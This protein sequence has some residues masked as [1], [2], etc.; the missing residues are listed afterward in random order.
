MAFSL[1]LNYFIIESRSEFI[2][3]R[4]L[5]KTLN[6][7]TV[8]K[9]RDKQSISK[10][11]STLKAWVMLSWLCDSIRMSNLVVNYIQIWM[12]LITRDEFTMINWLCKE[13][14]IQLWPHLSFKM[15]LKGTV[16][17]SLYRVFR[18]KLI[19]SRS[20]SQKRLSI[21]TRQA[22]GVSSLTSGQLDV[23]L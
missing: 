11:T 9:Q 17:V 16:L 19:C 3:G 14:S 2:V 13:M 21:L 7:L 5:V 22:S 20:K 23:S 4:A 15:E 1:R 6:R 10:T 8:W 18:Q 12:E